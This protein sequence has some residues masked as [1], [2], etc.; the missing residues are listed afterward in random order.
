M[1]KILCIFIGIYALAPL[2]AFADSIPTVSP[3][4]YN[5]SNQITQRIANTPIVFS[6]LTPGGC[7][8][9]TSLNVA[10]TT[11][12]PCGSGSGGGGVATTSLTATY[13]LVV[14]PSSSAINFSLINMATTTATCAGSVSCT[15][16]VVIGSTPITITGSNSYPFT[17]AGN[18]T[19]TLTQFNGGL[20]AYASSTVGNG[21][22]A[23]GLTISG[24]STTTGLALL[25][26]DLRLPYANT[27]DVQRTIPTT[28]G[29]EVDIGNFVLSNGASNLEIWITVPSGSYS[30]NKR[31][32]MPVSY[33]ATNNTWEKAIPISTTGAYSGNDADLEINVNNFTASLRIRRTAGSVAGTAD[34]TIIQQGVVTDI[35]TPSTATGSASA[36]TVAYIGTSLSQINGKVGV[37]IDNPGANFQFA[38]EPAGGYSFTSWAGLGYTIPVFMDATQNNGGS[39]LGASVPVLVL[40]RD[41]VSGQSYP[42]F[43]EFKLARYANTGT[44]AKT[45]LDFALTNGDGD[46]SGTNVLTLQSGGNVGISTT[47]PGSLLSLNNIANF[48]AATSTFYSTGGIN[49]TGGGCFS[50]NGTCVGG[51]GGAFASTTLLSD[52]NTFSGNNQFTA[53]TTFTKQINAQQASTT[54]FTASGNIYGSI[55]HDTSGSQFQ[56]Y[57]GTSQ[58]DWSAANELSANGGNLGDFMFTWTNGWINLVHAVSATTTNLYVTG[59]KSALHLGDSNGQVVAYAGSAPCTNQVALSLSAIGVITCTS[60][61]NAMLAH[62][63]IGLNGTTLTL[64]DTSDTISAASSTALSDSNT[65][66][67]LQNFAGAASSTLFSSYGPAYF[68]GSATSTFSSTGALT[69]ATPLATGSGGTGSSNLGSGVVQAASG[70]LSAA[71]PTRSFIIGVASTT[72]LVGSTTSPV[73]SF[74]FGITV[75]S[76]SCNVQPGGAAAEIEWEYAN[77]TAYT[78][79]TPTYLAASTT[80]GI[81]AISS[82]NTPTA[83]ATSTLIVGNPTGSAISAYCTFVGNST[84]I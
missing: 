63:T 28:V 70:A 46:T 73:F 72:V 57:S 45:Q 41:G 64:G 6:G 58:L 30:Q 69:L 21:G 24:N 55:F 29:N 68:G 66:S 17:A 8:Q 32:F 47:T 22:T 71:N 48:T 38:A 31:Y 39:S 37:N 84:T 15:G 35:F 81:V 11:G 49:L 4:F 43:A 83:A 16:F 82:N 77:P 78:T 12:T 20:T 50:I 80:P 13:P 5:N 2:G 1:K 54:N 3:F 40:G 18:A 75:T 60:V 44:N 56:F 25:S 62:S 14:T 76:L 67:K 65:W 61:S 79:V 19:S 23:G 26:G 59:V 34:V 51:S 27:Y 7:L 10:T 52:N 53:S 36:P 74:P 9:L 42:N 33:N